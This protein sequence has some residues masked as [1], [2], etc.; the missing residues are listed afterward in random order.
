MASHMLS[1]EPGIRSLRLGRAAPWK[2]T[3]RPGLHWPRVTGD[4][5]L[6]EATPLLAIGLKV[7]P[8]PHRGHL[9]SPFHSNVSDLRSPPP[10]ASF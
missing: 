10:A 2:V 7:P 3:I 1:L 9:K 4:P 5:L 6:P 8:P